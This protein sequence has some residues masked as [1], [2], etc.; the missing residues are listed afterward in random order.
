MTP[1]WQDRRDELDHWD[2][3]VNSKKLMFCITSNAF[4][5]FGHPIFNDGPRQPKAPQR[6]PMY[7]RAAKGTPMDDR[8]EPKVTPQGAK[9]T[10]SR[11]K[12]VQAHRTQRDAKVRPKE[13]KTP[14][15][16]QRDKI[17]PQT[18]C[19]FGDLEASFRVP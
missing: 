2:P 10:Q 13:A 5:T 15:E 1:L 8:W 6:D 12:G 18:H 19:R 14:K 11:P 4:H 16:S 3:D 17:Y 9:G 7:P